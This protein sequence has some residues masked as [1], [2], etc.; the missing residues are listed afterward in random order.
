MLFVCISSMSTVSSTLYH[1]LA[2]ANIHSIL[3]QFEIQISQISTIQIYQ[4]LSKNTLNLKQVYIHERMPSTL[5]I[6]F[7]CKSSVL[8]L[9]FPRKQRLNMSTND[10]Y[11]HEKSRRRDNLHAFNFLIVPLNCNLIQ[12]VIIIRCEFYLHIIDT[13]P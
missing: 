4:Y 10:H 1:K 11:I 7:S 9:V 2:S 3:P 5:T 13:I 8:H 12:C 6:P